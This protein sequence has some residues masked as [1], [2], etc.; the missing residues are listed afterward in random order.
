MS[1][2]EPFLKFTVKSVIPVQYCSVPGTERM[3]MA[4][5]VRVKTYASLCALFLQLHLG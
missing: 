3:G 2:L 4:L 1:V 5:P